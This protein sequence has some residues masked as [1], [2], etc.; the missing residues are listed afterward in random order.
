MAN[1]GIIGGGTFGS[2]LARFARFNG[3]KVEVWDRGELYAGHKCAGYFFHNSSGGREI[4]LQLTAFGVSPVAR[5]QMVNGAN[6]RNA[7]IHHILPEK[8]VV[9][10]DWKRNGITSTHSGL[11][12]DPDTPERF[13]QS[14]DVVVRAGGVW[15]AEIP[16]DTTESYAA[17]AL[18]VP[19]PCSFTSVFRK[20]ILTG[21]N[22]YQAVRD[23]YSGYFCSGD[24]S[25][26]HF[27]SARDRMRVNNIASQR[28]FPV[29]R[30]EFCFGRRTKVA[31]KL[32]HDQ[33]GVLIIGGGGL[34]QAV[35]A[36]IEVLKLVEE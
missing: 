13:S 4:A 12:M 14:Y 22:L 7:W 15:N 35:K 1:I 8:V 20:N 34:P 5:V 23:D 27:W 10:P 30:S 25:S 36:A 26:A 11:I 21:H 16:G 24:V 19:P 17:G 3:H 31:R 28:G 6:G 18:I 2:I 32:V 29:D 9:S 33:D